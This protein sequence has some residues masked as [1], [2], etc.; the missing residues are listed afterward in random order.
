MRLALLSILFIYLGFFSINKGYTE[1]NYTGEAC[2][3]SGIY[4]QQQYNQLM[5]NYDVKFY[6]LDLEVSDTTTFI[7]GSTTILIKVLESQFNEIVFELSDLMTIDSILVN[8]NIVD[9]TH[10]DDE[11]IIITD[12]NYGIST[13]VY[14]QIFYSGYGKNLARYSGIYNEQSLLLDKRVTYTVSEPF[15]SKEWFPCKQVLTDKADSVYVFITTDTQLKAGSNGILTSI[16]N[17]PED[18]VRYEWKSKYPIVY[19]LISLAVA[20]YYDYSFYTKIEGASDSILVQNY[21][22][23][24]QEYISNNIESINKTGDLI[25]L[26]SELFG[27][28]PY[29]GEKY[30]HCIVPMGGGMEHQTMTTLGNFTFILVAHELAHQWFGDNVTCG[31]W[32]D[33]WINEGF[34]SYAEYLAY[35]YLVSEESAELWMLTAHDI[36]FLEPWGSIYIP[37]EYLDD[38]AR[39][40]NNRLSYK[41]GAAIIHMIRHEIQ[42][43][44]LFFNI[45]REFQSDFRDSVAVG[46]DFKNLL[47]EKTGID[48]TDFFNQW[49]FGEGYPE[50]NVSWEY[51]N[52][53]LF[54]NSF[55]TTSSAVTPLFK[56]LTE[57]RIDLI[58]GDTSIF[59]RQASNYEQYKIYMPEKVKSIKVDPD[60]RLL[61]KINLQNAFNIDKKYTIYPNP[62]DDKILIYFSEPDANYEIYITDTLGKIVDNYRCNKQI[63]ELFIDSLPEGLYFL[64][65]KDEDKL[66]S[67]KFIKI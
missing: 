59:L 25:K 5:D 37:E 30:G 15:Y 29:A 20:D 38:P 52:D 22:Y 54:I 27:P 36:S 60:N 19:Y 6:K 39:I 10:Q 26:Y 2:N 66:Y 40:F 11:I 62:G 55:Q 16:V 51:A 24:T 43:D 49:Y 7:K 3:H 50:L 45:L 67:S 33:I 17:L 46:L 58:K 28:Y 34:A 18:K 21:V 35:E 1:T 12:M 23:N 42:N 47:E 44:T 31:S 32:Q 56:T 57:Y 41:K 65:I 14:V 13:L 53:T 8:S 64:L 61:M 48:F 63:Y 4:T 9:F